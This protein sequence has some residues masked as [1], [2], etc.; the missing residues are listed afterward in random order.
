MGTDCTS[1]RR[2]PFLRISVEGIEVSEA[3]RPR[4]VLRPLSGRLGVCSDAGQTG[5]NATKT[6]VEGDCGDGW[7][8]SA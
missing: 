7:G 6:R 3:V 5:Q 4:C 2:N 8:S 1:V